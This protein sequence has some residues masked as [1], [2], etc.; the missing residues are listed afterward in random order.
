MVTSTRKWEQTGLPADCEIWEEE[1]LE[2][3]GIKR[4]GVPS[5]R[6]PG[7]KPTEELAR[8][9]VLT[10]WELKLWDL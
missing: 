6:K 2:K 8:E 1:F 10:R 9:K 3:A 4:E 5:V 7:D